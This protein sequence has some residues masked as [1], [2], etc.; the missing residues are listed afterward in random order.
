MYHDA[1]FDENSAAARAY[2]H[3]FNTANADYWQS[4]IAEDKRRLAEARNEG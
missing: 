2:R 4:L 3:E 1:M